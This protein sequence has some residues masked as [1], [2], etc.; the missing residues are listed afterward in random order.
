MVEKKASL[1]FHLKDGDRF[2]QIIQR[3]SDHNNTQFFMDFK[4]KISIPNGTFVF[5]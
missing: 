3:V 4:M 1:Q 5:V 2:M